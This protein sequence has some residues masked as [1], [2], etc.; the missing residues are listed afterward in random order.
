MNFEADSMRIAVKCGQTDCLK[1]KMCGLYRDPE[2]LLNIVLFSINFIAL[3]NC[4]KI[5]F[6]CL[7]CS[8]VTVLLF[9]SIEVILR[10]IVLVVKIWQKWLKVPMY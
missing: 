9:E 10:F 3:W 5:L 1:E 2:Y 6:V 7:M 8:I 4:W